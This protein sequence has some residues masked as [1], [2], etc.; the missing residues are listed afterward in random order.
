MTNPATIGKT[1]QISRELADDIVDY[2]EI[3]LE[4][5]PVVFW[6]VSGGNTPPLLFQ[7]LVREHA[8][9]S[10]WKKVHVFWADERCVDPADAESNYGT[11][12]EALL[13]LG[14][15]EKQLHP[16]YRGGDVVE[17]CKA[18]EQRLDRLVPKNSQGLPQLDLVLLGLGTDGHTASLFPGRDLSAD[19]GCCTSVQHPESG[20]WRITLTLQTLNAVGRVIFFVLGESKASVVATILSGKAGLVFPAGQINPVRGSLEWYLDREAAQALD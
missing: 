4:D 18:Y 10:L 12:R 2:F 20:Q 19:P 15:P 11:S 6:A 16:M 17:A 14:I 7:A 1:R 9:L 3:L 13:D 5:Q 8:G